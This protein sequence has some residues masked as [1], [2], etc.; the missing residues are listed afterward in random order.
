M[1]ESLESS[2][3]SHACDTSL[4]SFKPTKKLYLELAYHHFEL[5][6][7]TDKWYFFGY[8]N[9]AGNLYKD[10]GDEYDIILKYKATKDIDLLAIGAYL[11]AGNFITKNDISQNDSSKMFFQFVYKFNTK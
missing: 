2:Q 9:K 3:L 4:F 11:K 10:I 8:Q 5:A 1:V 6:E 7:A